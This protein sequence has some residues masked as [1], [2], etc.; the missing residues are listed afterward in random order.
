MICVHNS[1]SG[2]EIIALQG[3]NPGDTLRFRIFDNSG[4]GPFSPTE[5]C[6]KKP[7]END[8]CVNATEI[9]QTNGISFSDYVIDN[10]IAAT[11]NDNCGLYYS[12]DDL[13]YR[14]MAQDTFALILVN[15]IHPGPIVQPIIEYYGSSCTGNSLGCTDKREYFANNLIIGQSYYFKIYSKAQNSGK[16][17]FAISVTTPQVN[18]ACS[19]SLLLSAGTTDQCTTPLTSTNISS[20]IDN[21]SWFKFVALDSF[22]VI[23]V[24]NGTSNKYISIFSHCDSLPV[25]FTSNATESFLE[26]AH[27]N[28]DST[29]YIQVSGVHN[30]EIIYDQFNFDICVLSRAQNDFTT[31]ATLILPGNA[32]ENAMTGSTEGATAS[33]IS[34]PCL[35][36]SIDVWYKFTPM[37]AFHKVTITPL[38]NS[39]FVHFSVYKFPDLQTPIECVTGLAQTATVINLNGLSLSDIY[40]IRVE[41]NNIY[42][43]LLSRGTFNICIS[44]PP[45]N[46]DCSNYEEIETNKLHRCFYKTSGTTIN[47]TLQNAEPG[48]TKPNVWYKIIDPQIGMLITVTPTTA[49]FD[50][51]IRLFEKVPESQAAFNILCVKK[52]I[53][54][55]LWGE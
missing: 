45:A 1:N 4:S 38:S 44:S 8:Q 43:A 46:D 53:A 39:S 18:Y 41:A 30:S 15:T 27:F 6:V 52:Y 47:A 31:G 42:D 32:C 29:Y 37:H 49:G 9:I 25:A 2:N 33:L 19:Q 16:G 22:H 28:T 34:G 40:Y 35:Q 21:A 12:D 23:K 20:G 55:Y 13:W 17:K 10:S 36:N 3:L 14:F 50:P 11:G 24:T 48:T 5:V 26:Y 7:S 51:K 54:I